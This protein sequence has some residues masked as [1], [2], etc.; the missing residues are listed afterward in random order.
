MTSHRLKI[1]PKFFDAVANG[2]K[3][4]EVRKADRDYKIGDTINLGEW[5]QETWEKGSFNR[6]CKLVITYILTHDQFPEGVPEGYVILA[7][8]VIQ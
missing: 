6:N 5:I 3:T 1:S 4:F 7:V 8:K 2:V